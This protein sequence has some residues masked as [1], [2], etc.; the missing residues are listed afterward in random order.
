MTLRNPIDFRDADSQGRQILEKLK[1]EQLKV[2]DFFEVWK[3]GIAT[4]TFSGTSKYLGTCTADGGACNGEC[5]EALIACY[6]G[7]GDIPCLDACDAAYAACLAGCPAESC[8][9]SIGNP[10]DSYAYTVK[11]PHSYPYTSLEKLPLFKLEKYVNGVL[12]DITYRTP[13]FAAQAMWGPDLSIPEFIPYVTKTHLFFNDM[14]TG[15]GSPVLLDGMTV[16]YR[17]TF[18]YAPTPF[19]YSTA[20]PASLFEGGGG[21]FCHQRLLDGDENREFEIELE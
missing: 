21:I 9:G 3:S 13:V 18:F 19:S 5:V 4:L 6:D 11:I 8:D 14:I 2:H 12:T 10:C 17:V 7:C 20:V 15:S 16:K 1:R